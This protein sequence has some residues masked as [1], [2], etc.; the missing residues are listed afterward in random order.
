[1]IIG[2]ADTEGL[3]I[4][5]P[6]SL[7][8]ESEVVRQGGYVRPSWNELQRRSADNRPK[9]GKDGHLCI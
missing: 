1:M 3:E 5:G 6:I 7:V 9:C 4:L 8:L 2:R